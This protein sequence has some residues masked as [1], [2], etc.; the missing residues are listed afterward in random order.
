MTVHQTALLVT[1]PVQ[2]PSVSLPSFCKILIFL[3]IY[4]I[5]MLR[6]ENMDNIKRYREMNNNKY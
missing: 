1:C 3:I 2:R 6:I 4:V 5:H